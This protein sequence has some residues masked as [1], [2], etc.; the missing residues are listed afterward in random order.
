MKNCVNCYKYM[1]VLAQTMAGFVYD[2]HPVY[3]GKCKDYQVA[4]FVC[5]D[6]KNKSQAHKH[7]DEFLNKFFKGFV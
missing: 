4:N 5:K 1:R 2:C 6:W 3:T 7:S